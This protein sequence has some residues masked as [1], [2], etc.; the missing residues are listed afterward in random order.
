M[1]GVFGQLHLVGEGNKGRVFREELNIDLVDTFILEMII[2]FHS[3]HA[4]KMMKMT[5]KEALENIFMPY[6]RGIST[7]TGVGLIDMYVLKI[8]E[9]YKQE[10]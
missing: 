4:L 6:F 3:S 5:R 7:P 2:M 1:Q 10:R 9:I 8:N